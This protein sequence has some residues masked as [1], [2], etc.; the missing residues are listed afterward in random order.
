MS[1]AAANGEDSLSTKLSFNIENH[2]EQLE[3]IASAIE[4]IGHQDNW[5]A[6]LV[7]RVNLVLEEVGL[8]VIKYGYDDDL[9]HEIEFTVVSEADAITIDIWDDGKPFDPLTEGPTVD[10]DA[11]I[12]DRSIGGL[13][14]HF[15]RTLMDN[16]QYERVHDRNHLTIVAARRVE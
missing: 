9:R 6:E 5:P 13:G 11:P 2:P 7:Y 4:Q 3:R 1:S 16:V 15:M 14:I 12:E 8:N 10:V